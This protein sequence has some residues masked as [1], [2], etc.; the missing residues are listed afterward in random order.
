MGVAAGSLAALLI[1]E[2]TRL[3]GFMEHG[4]R[5]AAALAAHDVPH[6]FHV[7]SRGPH[8]LGLARQAGEAGVWPDLAEAWL[9]ERLDTDRS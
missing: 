3:F 8:S 6:A 4:Y 9:R 7:F 5:L 1:S 2:H